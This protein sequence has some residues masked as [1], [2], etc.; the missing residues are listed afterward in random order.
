MSSPVAALNDIGR[1]NAYKLVFTKLRDVEN[2][3]SPKDLNG[4][5]LIDVVEE[6]A[7][8]LRNDDTIEV[9]AE[10]HIAVERVTRF[11]NNI[12][13]IEVMSGKSGE[14]GIVHDLEGMADDIPINEMQAP[15]SH[16]RAVLFS[17]DNGQMAM[18]FSE[19]NARSSGARNLLTLLK[20][21]WPHLNTGTKFNE[22]RVIMSEAL[23][24]GGKITEVEV[25]L[26]RRSSDLADGALSE[27]GTYS[28]VF[29]PDR[30]NPLPI[31]LLEAFRKNPTKAF[32]YVELSQS[33]LDD[34]EI[35]VSV[36]IDGHKRKIRVSDPDDGVYYHEELNGPGQPII[37]DSELIEFCSEEAVTCFERS[38]YCWDPS[39]SRANA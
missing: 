5:S 29:R 39:W 38:G 12:L 19:Y 21:A 9:S 28:H 15:M 10:T 11:N 35:F 24:D 23:S 8:G 26:T 22:R 37:T 3:L 16:S 30:K 31:R 36:D 25:R 18:W 33:D 27:T 1:I 2:T 14:P 32:E 17:P 6:W 34:R 13:I 4:E 7:E 20:K